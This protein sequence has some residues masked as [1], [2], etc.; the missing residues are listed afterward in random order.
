MIPRALVT[1][2]L[3][4]GCGNSESAMSTP[5]PPKGTPTAPAPVLSAFSPLTGGFSQVIAPGEPLLTL[6]TAATWWENGTPVTA[7]V[8]PDGSPRGARWIPGKQALRV[9]LGT[10]DLAARAW[11]PEPGLAR[12]NQPGPRHEVPVKRTA[13]FADATHVAIV[14][15]SRDKLNRASSELVIADAT[16]K[17]RGRQSL[18]GLVDSIIASADRV[19][20]DSSNK[21]HL[22]DL[23]AKLIAEPELKASARL[24]NE[25]AGMFAIPINGGGVALVRP[26]DGVVV[27]TWDIDA[28]DAV[29]IPNGLVVVESDGMVHV[30]C[31]HG[32]DIRE[33]AKLASGVQDPVVQRVGDRIVVAGAGANPVRVAAFASPCR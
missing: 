22:Y 12:F 26:S 23:D 33:V 29:A 4:A 9:G 1:L 6:G 21:I 11:Q 8:S 30:G 10:L 14:I 5:T 13:W 16:G 31:V 3:C 20:V 24:V 18:P 19:V 2:L 15:E 7:A 28:N 25:G 32:H 27:A 17:V